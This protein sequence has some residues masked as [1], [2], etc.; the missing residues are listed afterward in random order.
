MEHLRLSNANGYIRMTSSEDFIKQYRLKAFFVFGVA[1]LILLNRLWASSLFTGMKHPVFLFQQN[2]WAYQLFLQINIH[3]TITGHFLVALL[4]DLALFTTPALFIITLKRAYAIAFSGL[5]LIYFFT[6]N[7]VTGH[8]YHGLIA[9]IVITLPFWTSKEQHFNLLWQAARYYWLYIFVSAALWKILRGSIFYTEQLS[10]ILQAQQL[11][12]LLQKPDSP[13]AQMVQYLIANNTTAHAV[14]IINVLVQLSFLIGFFTK[15]FDHLL[16][17]LAFIFCL[18]NYFV[19]SIVSVEL[20]ILNLTLLNWEKIAPFLASPKYP[21]ITPNSDPFG[22]N[23]VK[24]NKTTKSA[25]L[26]N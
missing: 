15:K 10:N 7:L 14:L 13:H 26:L 23:E 16:F 25:H 17:A 12:L 9:A 4:F 3:Q 2:E 5:L 18:A 20:L 1:L 22:I 21:K 6:F 11:H 8:H 24:S 19:M